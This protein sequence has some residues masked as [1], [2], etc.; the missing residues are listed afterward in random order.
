M[1]FFFFSDPMVGLAFI[2]R[3]H[4]YGSVYITAIFNKSAYFKTVYEYNSMLFQ[5]TVG[6]YQLLHSI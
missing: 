5:A 2:G 4:G 1:F 3:T 6:F